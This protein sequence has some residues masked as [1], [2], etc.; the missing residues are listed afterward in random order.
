MAR[1]NGI[2]TRRKRSASEGSTRRDEDDGG[3][4]S[5][6]GGGARRVG[7]DVATTQADSVAAKSGRAAKLFPFRPIRN[8]IVDGVLFMK[9]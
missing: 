3:G 7:S 4:Y 9:E 2:I 5:S 8:R 1:S 6:L